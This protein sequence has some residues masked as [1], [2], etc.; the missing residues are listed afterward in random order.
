MASSMGMATCFLA[1]NK[2]FGNY[3]GRQRRRN[4]EPVAYEDKYPKGE[5]FVIDVQS[6]L[7][8]RPRHRLSQHEVRQEHGLQARRLG[9]AYAFPNFVKEMYF[10]SETAML[11]ISG[12]PGREVQYGKGQAL[13]GPKRGG[14]CCPVG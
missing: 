5:Y 14:G 9:P 1:S 6:P 4:V 12:V 7:H 3:L 10:D 11:V 2:V 13:E 8:Q